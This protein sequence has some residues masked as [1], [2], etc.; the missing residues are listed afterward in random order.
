MRTYRTVV[1]DIGHSA[2]SGRRIEDIYSIS[3]ILEHGNGR[4]AVR[5]GKEE[6]TGG[7][8]ERRR[9]VWRPD[10]RAAE[11]ISFV[12]E[13]CMCFLSHSEPTSPPQRATWATP[14]GQL[15]AGVQG[16]PRRKPLWTGRGV[17][18]GE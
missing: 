15:A 12:D 4:E 7:E 6:E 18:R 5:E 1:G 2:G 9:E 14:S 8:Q 10:L 3:G 13:R 11:W 16:D 17:G